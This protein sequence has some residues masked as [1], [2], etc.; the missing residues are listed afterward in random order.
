[1]QKHSKTKETF[2]PNRNE[3]NL[4]KNRCILTV[5]NI[6]EA[7]QYSGSGIRLQSRID[8]NLSPERLITRGVECY[9]LAVSTQSSH[10]VL[11]N[12]HTAAITKSV[13]AFILTAEV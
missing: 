5:L 1:M 11:S 13:T 8:V 7:E 6:L 3:N 9:I 4:A 10:S 2:P 12:L